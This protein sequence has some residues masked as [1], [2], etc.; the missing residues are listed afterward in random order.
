MELEGIRT[1]VD[2]FG[3]PGRPPLLLLHGG[4]SANEDWGPLP[5]LL[6]ADFLVVAPERRGHGRT[7]DS[8]APFTYEAM[9]AETVAAARTL[10][11]PPTHVVGWSDGGIVGLM[12]ALARPE[13]VA[14]LVLIGANFDVAGLTGPFATETDPDAP[15]WAP[16]RACYERLSPDGPGHWPVVLAKTLALWRTAPHLDPLS[17]A[18]VRTRTLVLVGDDDAVTLEHTGALFSA[19]PDADLAVVPHAS[20]AVV[21]ERPALVTALVREFLAGDPPATLFPVRRRRDPAAPGPR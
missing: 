21:L 13:L 3:D 6:S 7:P 14:R 20:H 4:L 17:I 15:L 16:M 12:L 1:W 8:E 19:L 10:V 2:R 11:R 18:R 5:E 9:V